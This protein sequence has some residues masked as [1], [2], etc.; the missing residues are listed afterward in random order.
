MHGF[1]AEVADVGI[2]NARSLVTGRTAGVEWVN[3]NGPADL[4]RDGVEIQQKFTAAG[5][6]LT[7]V[8]DHVRRYPDFSASGRYRIPCD[9]YAVV[10]DL[11]EMSQEDARR[12]LTTSGGGP[13]LRDWRR[14]HEFFDSSGISFESL[15]PSAMTYSEAQ[16]GAIRS[17]VD[18]ERSS[19][20]GVDAQLR[21]EIA[22][23]SRASPRQGVRAAAGGAAIE[24]AGALTQSILALRRSGK[25][26]AD[27]TNEDWSRVLST[28]GLSAAKGGIRASQL[29]ALTNAVGAPS[30]LA[31]G[32]VTAGMAVAES[33]YRL[34]SGEAG[35]A[36]F[37]D[38]CEAV[39]ME[40]A[41]SAVS[42]SV[43]QALIPVPA[44]GAVLGGSVGVIMHRA[45]RGALSERERRLIDEYRELH[46]SEDAEM[47]ALRQVLTDELNAFCDLLERAFAPSVDDAVDASVALAA[48]VG[49]P[50]GQI[51]DTEEKVAAYFL[52]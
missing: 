24:A 37:I 11:W 40:A 23:R 50:S 49:V 26:L 14:V 9:H 20:R 33:A 45:A 16:V 28:A 34:R 4:I 3:D 38:T 43:G 6:S 19:I 25:R 32:L 5:Y 41:I 42:T 52:M 22:E 29:Y 47:E 35:E 44:L 30:A 48:A 15:E 2:V 10:K 36:E 27:F 46:A 21:Q 8:L 7:A 17:T 39:C 13:S 1:I 18:A 31:G 12:E 51:L